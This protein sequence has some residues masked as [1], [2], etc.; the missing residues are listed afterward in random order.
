MKVVATV[1]LLLLELIYYSAAG[2]QQKRSISRITDLF[3]S[4]TG[5]VR[6]IY[7]PSAG[8]NGPV[9]AE[10]TWLSMGEVEEKV[11]DDSVAPAVKGRE[12]GVHSFQPVVRV[13]ITQSRTSN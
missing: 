7:R 5:G 10:K 13:L 3:P 2:G 11:S 12:G 1:T 9:P 6:H 8:D 4:E